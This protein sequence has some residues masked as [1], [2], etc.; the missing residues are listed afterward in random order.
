MLY[1]ASTPLTEPLAILWMVLTVYALFRYREGGNLW[2]LGG[3]GLA[4]FCGTLT[5]YDGWALLPFEALFVLLARPQAWR[6]RIRHTALFSLIAGAGPILWLLHNDYRFGN[7]LE[8]YN[9]PGSTQAQYAHQ[10][11]TTAFR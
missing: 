11:A 9:G 1:L 7:A 5:R 2:T 10:L 8:F 4:A 6:G 3:A